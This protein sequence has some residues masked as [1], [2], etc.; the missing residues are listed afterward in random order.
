MDDVLS[1]IALILYIAGD[2]RALRGRHLVG[3]QV[4]ALEER[5]GAAGASREG[6][7]LD[8][9]VAAERS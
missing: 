5:Q 1:I 4:L 2:P 6:E 9:R 7:G 3:R 8:G